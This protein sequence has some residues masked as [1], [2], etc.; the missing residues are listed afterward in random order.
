MIQLYKKLTNNFFAND[1]NPKYQKSL[2]G[3]RGLAVLIVLLSHASN[4]ELFLF[5]LNFSGFGKFGV[6]LFFLL[7]S[8]LLDRQICKSL[9]EKKT[10]KGYWINYA[11]RRFVRI[12]PMFTIMLILWYLL[13]LLGFEN[14]INSPKI[15]VQH[16][17]L[18]KGENIFW[19]IP[20]EFKYYILSP[21][22][23]IIFSKILFW[24]KKHLNI[25]IFSLII[26]SLITASF[27]NL[28]RTS[29]FKYLSFFLAGTL[30]SIYE[31]LYFTKKKNKLKYFNFLGILSLF[32]I[33]MLT[34]SF[35]KFLFPLN[36][37]FFY[38]PFF[39]SLFAILWGLVLISTKTGGLMNK[40]F[41]FKFLR[42]IGVI[43]FSAYL[44][45]I[46]ILRFII[47][48]DFVP[49]S[50][51]FYVFMFLVFF[52]SSISYLL[53]EKPLSSIRYNKKLEWK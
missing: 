25:F 29:T 2:D 13:H 42:F 5:N 8:Y 7:S 37:Y 15:I 48:L 30:I 28:E 22:L 1:N 32:I 4:N 43:S 17:L 39:Y 49:Q 35:W 14:V 53:I 21:F 3:L 51:K 19:S 16:L 11:L 20:V 23:M 44:I 45:H 9:I 18:I 40:I 26:I 46:P 41:E 24:K 10:S 31:L 6:Y 38:E 36:N 33:F 47:S 12:Y 27:F 34:P 50:Y 52:F